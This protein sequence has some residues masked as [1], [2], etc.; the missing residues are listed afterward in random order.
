[1][2]A[3]RTKYHNPSRSSALRLPSEHVKLTSHCYN[4]TSDCYTARFGQEPPTPREDATPSEGW[5]GARPTSAQHST[6]VAPAPRPTAQAAVAAMAA[7]ASKAVRHPPKACT[8]PPRHQLST[9]QRSPRRRGQL[10]RRQ[11]RQRQQRRR[12]RR[13]RQRSRLAM[14]PSLLDGCA[15]GGADQSDHMQKSQ[16][17]AAAG[18]HAR[19]R[20]REGEHARTNRVRRRSAAAAL[21]EAAHS[22]CPQLSAPQDCSRI[23]L[24]EAEPVEHTQGQEDAGVALKE[25]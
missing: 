17:Q 25:L 19:P 13:R 14:A 9:A 8:A 6:A 24:D 18:K 3:N 21:T 4:A 23:G 12:K 1:M 16:R 7:V 10:L 22:R 15:V 11:R 5:H 20:S 2:A